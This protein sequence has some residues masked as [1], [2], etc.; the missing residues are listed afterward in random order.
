MPDEILETQTTEVTPETTAVPTPDLSDVEVMSNGQEVD[1]GEPQEG[2]EEA[3]QDNQDTPEQAPEQDIQK[4]VEALEATRTEINK[5]VTDKGLNFDA[6]QRTYDENGALTD[7]QYQE[8]EA[9]G[10]PKSAVDACIA[11]MQAKVD[12][13]VATVKGFAGGETGFEQMSAFVASQG[14]A[15]VDAFNNIMTTANVGTIKAYM[16]G[17]KAQMVGKN[18]TS[19]PSV[20]GRAASGAVE[21]FTDTNE[22]TAAMRDPRYGRDAKY[23]KSVEARVAASTSIFN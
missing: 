14:Q 21:G 19:N 6:L 1:L 2:G 20:M 16:E 7:A 4:E 9:A 22:M 11:G 5:M 23:T 13:F 15:Q 17:I 8:L 10:F 3:P 18:G 12:S